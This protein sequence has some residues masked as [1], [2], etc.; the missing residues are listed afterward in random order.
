LLRLNVE[1]RTGQEIDEIV[2]LISKIVHA[3]MPSDTEAAT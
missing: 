2:G 1:A 3:Q